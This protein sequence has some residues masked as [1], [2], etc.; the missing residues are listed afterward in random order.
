MNSFIKSLIEEKGLTQKELAAV[1]GLTGPAVNQWNEDVTN[2]KVENLFLLSKLFH[3][4]VDELLEGKRVGESLEDKWRREYDI[5]EE[6]ARNAM[7]EHDKGLLLQCLA[8]VAKANNRFFALYERKVANHITADELKEWQ[9]I[10]RF[11]E[12]NIRRSHFFDEIILSSKEDRDRFILD[13]LAKKC[14]TNNK[15]AIMW[16]IKKIYKIE[17][18]RIDDS[19]LGDFEKDLLYDTDINGNDLYYDADIF[20]ARYN[21]L[22]PVEKDYIINEEYNKNRVGWQRYE[23]LYEMIKRGGNLLYAPQD[24]NLTNYDYKDLETLEGEIKPVPELDNAHAAIYEIYD[25]YS[26]ATYKQH[27][28]LIN[29][30]LM[31]QIEM[32]VKH[33]EKNPIKYW[34]YVKSNGIF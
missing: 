8:T 2:R 7:I 33:K 4:T 15:D 5:N 28:A 19:I 12:V 6:V 26:F 32:K 27:Q 13:Y 34:E 16:E 3:V 18:F 24:L 31:K 10:K 30:R 9:F 20:Y 22:T 21:I 14:G 23:H 17:D 25:N 1:L 29:H 11:Y